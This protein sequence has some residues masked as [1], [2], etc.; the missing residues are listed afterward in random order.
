[1]KDK[2]A[3][4]PPIGS[5]ALLVAQG[6]R[7]APRTTPIARHRSMH[8]KYRYG[9]AL[10]APYI[11]VLQPSLIRLWRSR[12]PSY[13]PSSGRVPVVSALH[14]T[15]YQ[16]SQ[17]LISQLTSIPPHRDTRLSESDK[18]I[19]GWLTLDNCPTASFRTWCLEPRNSH[20][21]GS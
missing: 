6:T 19:F 2:S 11:P 13:L 1:M 10:L 3:E 5:R 12:F 16:D 17:K 9:A 20:D 4:L 14:H 18:D 21:L 15:P 8:P 7:L